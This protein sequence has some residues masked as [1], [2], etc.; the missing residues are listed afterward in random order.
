MSAIPDVVPGRLH[1]RC[2]PRLRWMP[3]V[4][5]R[6]KYLSP[7]RLV[8]RALKSGHLRRLL[9]LWRDPWPCSGLVSPFRSPGRPG[10]DGSWAA[11]VRYPSFS[12]EVASVAVDYHEGVSGFRAGPVFEVYP[13]NT[14]FLL[15]PMDSAVQTTP[16]SL[17]IQLGRSLTVPVTFTLSEPIPSSDAP[18]MTFPIYPLPGWHWCRCHDLLR[19]FGIGCFFIS[20]RQDR[21]SSAESR[22]R[23]VSQERPFDAFCAPMDTGDC[24]LVVTG[25]PGR[26]YRITSYTGPVWV[27]SRPKWRFP[28][29]N[30]YSQ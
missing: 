18:A 12:V 28:V 30:Y 29:V 7:A 4:G 1:P 17:P 9:Q 6:T 25:L 14:G 19:R 21:W 20:S 2:L 22:T 10:V 3:I 8:D 13:D 16:G 24:P 27:R 11:S 26:P 15:R 23:D 5:S